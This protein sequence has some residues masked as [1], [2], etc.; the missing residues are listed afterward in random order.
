MFRNAAF[1][2]TAA[3]LMLGACAQ[4]STAPG[5]SAPADIR[6]LQQSVGD[7]QVTAAGAFAGRSNHV[8]TGSAAIA[9]Q[10]G[11]WVV[12]LGPDFFFDGA[13]DPHVALGKNGYD[14]NAS[15]AKL[16]SNNGQQIYAIPAGLD[17][18]NFS[19]IWIWCDQF[20]VPL[21]VASLTLT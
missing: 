8:T 6:S 13:P 20:S 16:Q 5:A 3:T 9:R 17:V 10:G 21:G 15:L 7:A 12:V 4:S 18:A 14:K 2:A 1:I 19:E 11:Q